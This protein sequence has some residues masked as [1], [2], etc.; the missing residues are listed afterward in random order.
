MREQA[1]SD[2]TQATPTALFVSALICAAAIPPR[3]APPILDGSSVTSRSAF[4][5]LFSVWGH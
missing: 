4:D 5:D 3:A 1:A 2:R